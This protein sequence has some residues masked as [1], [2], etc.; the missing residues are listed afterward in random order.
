MLFGIKKAKTA[1]KLKNLAAND[2]VNVK[3]KGWNWAL[4]QSFPFTHRL[5][6]SCTWNDR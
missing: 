3:F 2:M 4:N 6:F 1:F 5:C